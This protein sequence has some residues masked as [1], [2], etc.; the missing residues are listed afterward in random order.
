ML[1]ELSPLAVAPERLDDLAHHLRFSTGFG[2]DPVVEAAMRTALEAALRAVERR[3][4]RVLVARRFG[5]AAPAWEPGGRLTL[6]VEPVT[7]LVEIVLEDR[8]G[9]RTAH[10]AENFILAPESPPVVV[11]RRGAAPA[12][13]PSGGRVVATF[14]AGWAAWSAVPAELRQATLALAAG[15]F[16]GWRGDDA[17]A[18]VGTVAALLA[19]Y[20]RV[21]L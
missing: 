10:P 4:G 6:P 21:R 1:I 20:R 16:E 3:T 11:A 8:E 12:R 14:D 9:L 5:F 19:P 2:R 7:A 18:S 15:H 13:I 17:A